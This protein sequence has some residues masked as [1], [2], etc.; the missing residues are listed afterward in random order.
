MYIG[1]GI[2]IFVCTAAIVTLLGAK[3]N[4]ISHDFKVSEKS[5][6]Y[7]FDEEGNNLGPREIE[8]EYFL[9]KEAAINLV[10]KGGLTLTGEHRL[11]IGDDETNAIHI[12]LPDYTPSD[13]VK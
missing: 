2:K 9:R 13:N 3:T 12:D 7:E 1:R 4:F 8:S 6:G 5:I 11:T 10:N